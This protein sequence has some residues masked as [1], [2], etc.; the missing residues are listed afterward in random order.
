M[1]R[2]TRFTAMRPCMRDFATF[3]HSYASLYEYVMHVDVR[4]RTCLHV[5][6]I[7]FLTRDFM[8]A[9]PRLP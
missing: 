6:R 3:L 2:M 7:P 9:H 1:R 5:S 4:T 8:R